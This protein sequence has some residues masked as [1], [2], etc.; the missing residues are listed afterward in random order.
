MA[1][2]ESR[3]KELKESRS[4]DRYATQL[5]FVGARGLAQ[6]LVPAVLPVRLLK[7]ARA[8][9]S[10]AASDTAHAIAAD[11][12]LNT[13]VAEALGCWLQHHQQV[14]SLFVGRHRPALE[15]RLAQPVEGV[16]GRCGRL[17]CKKPR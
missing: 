3:I 7:L 17:Y 15:G 5:D 9:V 16:K 2:P 1:A 4:V 14:D 10:D 12:M 8:V 6:L 11:L 13:N